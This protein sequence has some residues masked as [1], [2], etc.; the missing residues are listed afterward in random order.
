MMMTMAMIRSS[1]GAISPGG[2][3]STFVSRR[4]MRA[5][6]FDSSPAGASRR[7]AWAPSRLFSR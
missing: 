4:Q 5:G 3:T 1:E 2:S 6:I 7:K